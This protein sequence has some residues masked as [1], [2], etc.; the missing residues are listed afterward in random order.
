MKSEILTPTLVKR[1]VSEFA[2]DLNSVHGPAHWMRV[3][4]N[5]L[6]LAQHTGANTRVVELFALFHD[7]CRE[8]DWTD[9][10][11]GPRGGDF[12]A[13]LFYEE[14]ALNCS[15]EEL[16]MLITACDGHTHG[17]VHDDATIGTC[18]DSDRLD[19]PR[20]GIEVDPG[21]LCTDVAKRAAIISETT[22]AAIA[23]R[24]KIECQAY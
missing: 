2:L 3:R 15:E 24:F 6:L 20:V 14:H 7:S 18:W 11:H 1:V 16:Q 19:L 21:L 9:P 5:G 23:W 8:N 13:Y 22:E 17:G 4:R 12:A 10:D